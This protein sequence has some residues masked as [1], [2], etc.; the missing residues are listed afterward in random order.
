MA[1]AVQIDRLGTPAEAVVRTVPDPSP[2]PGELLVRVHA[3]GVGPWDPAVASGFLGPQELPLT[4][5]AELAGEV[6]AVGDGVQ[7]YAV[8]DRVVSYPALN[9]AWA[10]LV[11]VPAAA[12]GRAPSGDLTAAAAL[13]VCAS[14]AWQAL[15][16]LGLPAGATLLVLGAGGA[17]GSFAVQLGTDRGLRVVG[18]ASPK[19][20]DR[21]AG[22]GA[23]TV[24]DYAGDWPAEL[25]AQGVR[26]DG[27]LDLV[28]R[29]ELRRAYP[30]LAPGAPLVTAQ[31]GLDDEQPP[32]GS[33]LRFVASRGDTATLTAISELVD[34]GRLTAEIARVY[35]LADAVQALQDAWAPHPPGKL[36]IELSSKGPA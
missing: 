22:F 23:D 8:G 5:G 33:T 6:T 18:T 4:L 15:A 31:P 29:D 32:Q 7:G 24:V 26:V 13:P 9:G 11:A 3:V 36:V 17:V 30:L 28:G 21:L 34:A 20:H 12:T 14:T 27:V 10:D 19:D 1:R 25:R 2:G 35:P 16:M